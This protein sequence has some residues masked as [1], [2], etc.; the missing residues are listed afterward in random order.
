MYGEMLAARHPQVTVDTDP[1]FVSDSGTWTSA[2]I[3][4]SFDLIL[5]LVAEDLGADV[6]LTAARFLVMFLHRS[7]NQA[8]FSAQLAIQLAD[9][10]P[11]RELQQFIA[12]HPDA[13]LSA[14]RLAKRVSMSLRHFTRVFTREVGSS[15]GRYVEQVRV[16]TAR[17]RLEE[18][19]H[20]LERIA[21]ESGFGS[22]ETLR[23]V[24]HHHLGV[25]PGGVPPRLH[26]HRPTAVHPVGRPGSRQS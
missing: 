10:R 23:R 11:I 26:H 3:T 17:R 6:A 21:N 20:T 8:Q 22:S 4:A 9:R 15:P 12:D 19:D 24:F 1:I 25:S 5:T 7:G 2:G 14:P 16:E 18:S 13:D